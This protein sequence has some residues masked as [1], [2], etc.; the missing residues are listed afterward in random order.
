MNNKL[1]EKLAELEHKQWIEWSAKIEEK[2][3][4]IRNYILHNENEKA[5]GAL[6]EK[7]NSWTENR[8]PYNILSEEEK[9]MDRVWADK[10]I[11]LIDK[12]DIKSE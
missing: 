8:R 7:I 4:E 9:N 6:Q 5:F 10:I 3:I 11:K 1:R 12:K 2:L